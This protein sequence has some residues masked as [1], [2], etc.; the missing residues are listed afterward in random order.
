[1]KTK[2]RD[3]Q[4]NKIAWFVGT[5]LAEVSNKFEKKQICWSERK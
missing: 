2:A 3:Q 5:G 4:I 1:M